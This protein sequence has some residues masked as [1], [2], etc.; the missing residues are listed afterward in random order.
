MKTELNKL[1]EFPCS[2][3]F[4]IMGNADPKLTDSI[5]RVIQQYAPGD[6]T[7]ITRPSSQGNYC[8]VSVTI[9]AVDVNQIESLYQVLSSIDGVITFNCFPSEK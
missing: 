1:L 3:T 4:K 2:F 5:L 8:S 7:P 9:Y 6:Y